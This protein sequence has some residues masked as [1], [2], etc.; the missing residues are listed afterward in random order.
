MNN[1]T[2]TES[3]RPVALVTGAA[4]RIGPAICR[5]LQARGWRVAAAGRTKQSFAALGHFPADAVLEGDLRKVEDC[6]RLVAA[7]EESLGPLSLL[8]NNA[9]GNDV[10]P[11]SFAEASPDYCLKILQVDLLAA[12]YLAQAALPSL[13]A[14]K[15]QIINISSVGVRHFLKGNFIY[16]A[17]KSALETLTE[18]MAFELQDDG[19]RANAVRVGAVPSPA[20]VRSAVAGLEPGLARRIEVDVMDE[21]ALELRRDGMPYGT[22]EDVAGVV[23]FLASTAARFIN[24]SVIAADG[25]F[26][27]NMAVRTGERLCELTRKSGD[28]IAGLWSRAPHEALAAWKKKNL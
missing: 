21:Y 17:A 22:A 6:Q 12:V 24:G 5:E 19:V 26:S 9:T 20:F 18:A 16:S 28:S 27:A 3:A 4:G 2:P 25:A 10:A 8:V 7:A 13:R 15:G 1:T 23:A 14:G 11:A